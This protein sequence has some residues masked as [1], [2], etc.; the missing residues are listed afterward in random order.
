LDEPHK[1]QLIALRLLPSL[2]GIEIKVK[3]S[4]ILVAGIAALPLAAP[5]TA[6]TATFAA[7]PAKADI[8]ISQLLPRLFL[9]A[10]FPLVTTSGA[11]TAGCNDDL[12]PDTD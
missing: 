9:Y 12:L 2:L 6:V 5:A 4:K 3:V 1:I 7:P 8:S 10:S 11:V